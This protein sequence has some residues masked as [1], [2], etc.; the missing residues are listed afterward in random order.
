MSNEL[1][2]LKPTIFL[3]LDR[4]REENKCSD[5]DSIYDFIACTCAS[6]I[7]EELIELIIEKMI[8]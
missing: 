7:S 6:Y 4:I 1:D 8:T 5:A 2:I 3:A